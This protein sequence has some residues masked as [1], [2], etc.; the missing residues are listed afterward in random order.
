MT[1][2]RIAAANALIVASA[3]MLAACGGVTY[4]DVLSH[5]EAHLYY[6]GSRVVS[7]AG[8]DEGS[9]LDTGR[10]PAGAT[11]NL[12]TDAT[13]SEIYAWYKAELSSRGWKLRKTET[14]GGGYELFTRGT[15][16]VFYVS[17]G[18]GTAT[19]EIRYLIIPASCATTDPIP[20]D[21]IGNC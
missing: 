5:P 11:T 21:R 10:T 12:A 16:D 1:T 3:A 13:L 4:K 19:Y 2:V 15:R 7:K 20:I 8:A 18:S 6:P 14:I 9:G 17:A